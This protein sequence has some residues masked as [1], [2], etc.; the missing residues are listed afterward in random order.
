MS[1]KPLP[2]T[3]TVKDS[4]INGLGLFSKEI[5]P[6]NTILGISHVKNNNYQHDVIRTPLGG[7]INHD[8]ETPNCIREDKGDHFELRTLRDIKPNEELTLKYTLY[9]P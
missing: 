2:D 9:I 7:F 8:G 5:I 3:L 6:K 1:Y 4:S